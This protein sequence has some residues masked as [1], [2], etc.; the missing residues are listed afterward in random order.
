MY[1]RL[2]P[3]SYGTEEN[4]SSGSSPFSGHTSAV[5]G[6]SCNASQ[7]SFSFHHPSCEDS[8]KNSSP[9][10]RDMILRS[11]HTVHPSLSQK[12]SHVAFVTRLP[13][14]LS[15]AVTYVIVR[16]G[17]R[18]LGRG[19][20]CVCFTVPVGDLVGDH[21]GQGLVARQQRGRGEGQAGVLHAAVRE[22]RRQAEHV[23]AGP[24]V[25]PGQRLGG[26]EEHLREKRHAEVWV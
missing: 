23:V 21:V 13:V 9:F 16:D 19:L 17:E 1:K 2:K 12:C 25:G 5:N 18:G 15:W 6:P 8:F 24:L 22:G 7:L 4:A 14:Q 3:F 20:Q 26:G 11:S 10:T